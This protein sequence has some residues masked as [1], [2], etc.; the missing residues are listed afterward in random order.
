MYKITC[1]T[2][3]VCESEVKARAHH[4]RPGAASHFGCS[5]VLCVYCSLFSHMLVCVPDLPC[6][7][8]EEKNASK[9][10]SLCPK[11]VCTL[12]LGICHGHNLTATALMSFSKLYFT[13]LHTTSHF[14]RTYCTKKPAREEESI[15][16]IENS[17]TFNG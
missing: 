6:L 1:A 4:H 16:C 10:H 15:E 8:I 7:H 13:H 17:S 2:M 14:Y 11:S 9:W 12:T 3:L 5:H